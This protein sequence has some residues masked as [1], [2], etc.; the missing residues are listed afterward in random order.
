MDLNTRKAYRS[1]TVNNV[2]VK[3][4][5][6]L[7]ATL[8]Q[9]STNVEPPFLKLYLHDICLLQQMPKG[10]NT[11]LL[12]ILKYCDF[13]NE[14]I[15]NHKRRKDIAEKLNT[16]IN[17]IEKALT[18]FVQKLILVRLSHGTYQLNPFI[19]SMGNWADIYKERV[20]FLTTI[21]YNKDGRELKTEILDEE[22]NAEGAL[23]I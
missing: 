13:T 15:L 7:N 6:I 23:N 17:T 14:I 3:T 2:D 20:S 10:S 22:V 9:Y 16:S 19:F 8:K 11:I 18:A 21:R 1:T 5:E 12:E 4:G